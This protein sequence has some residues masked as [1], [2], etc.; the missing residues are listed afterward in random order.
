MG[1]TSNVFGDPSLVEVLK[2]F[3]PPDP[4]KSEREV[5]NLH[6]RTS[7][8]VARKR[9]VGDEEGNVNPTTVMIRHIACRYSQ[10]QVMDILD[11]AGLRD[12]YDFVH[13]PSNPARQAN[14]GYVFVNFTSPA[15]VDECKARFDGLVFGSSCTRKKCSVVLAHKQGHAK[16][17][18][19]AL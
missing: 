6:V 14:L 18:T 4:P 5:A 19:V 8:S 17:C 13:L 12:K 1:F 2:V 3:P 16:T 7:F 9:L 10:D 11:D 15:Y